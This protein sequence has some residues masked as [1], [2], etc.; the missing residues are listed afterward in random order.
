MLVYLVFVEFVSTFRIKPPKIGSFSHSILIRQEIRSIAFPAGLA[1]IA[2]Y[3]TSVAASFLYGTL[4]GEVS[5]QGIGISIAL[6]TFTFVLVTVI[7]VWIL[8]KPFDESSFAQNPFQI[9]SA[10]ES[11]ISGEGQTNLTS[12]DLKDNLEKWRRNLALRCLGLHRD[13][14]GLRSDSEGSAVPRNQGSRFRRI[15]KL[16]QLRRLRAITGILRA[17]WSRIGI[18]NRIAM[19][20]EIQ[21]R[22]IAFQPWLLVVIFFFMVPVG[23][24]I[25]GLVDQINGRKDYWFEASSDGWA[26]CIILLTVILFVAYIVLR[27]NSVRR[28]F[29][30]YSEGIEWARVSIRRVEE[31]EQDQS[32][33]RHQEEELLAQV[34]SALSR[35]ARDSRRKTATKYFSVEFGKWSLQ[36]SKNID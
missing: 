27:V 22:M 29:N 11:I 20:F 1:V 13:E 5:E 18:F 30:V 14:R 12:I 17:S 33:R 25:F 31:F 36:I 23:V 9:V 15:R 3:V 34:Y 6:L 19:T 26:W 2:G 32:L 35:G 10:C 8:G 24:S 28:W 16:K 21:F 7:L 4:S